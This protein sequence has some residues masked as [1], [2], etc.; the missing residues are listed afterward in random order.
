[1]NI[2][3]LKN[4]INHDYAGSRAVFQPSKISNNKDESNP[5]LMSEGNIVLLTP[6]YVFGRYSY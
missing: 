3:G 4:S 6:L 5:N 2:N 1:M